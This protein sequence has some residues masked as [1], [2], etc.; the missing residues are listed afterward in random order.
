MVEIQELREHQQFFIMVKR[1]G[2]SFNKKISNAQNFGAAMVIVA[3]YVKGD[4]AKRS[5]NEKFAT[6]ENQG[7]LTAHI[8][9][10]EISH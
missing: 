6:K 2:C 1:G 7:S 3:D 5:N 10:F 8:P 4:D 9:L